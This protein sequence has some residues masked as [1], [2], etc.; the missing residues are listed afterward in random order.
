MSVCL[1]DVLSIYR[2]TYLGG[3]R[4]EGTAVV[5]TDVGEEG[6]DEPQG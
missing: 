5:G 3:K 1:V 6:S 2:E 4:V